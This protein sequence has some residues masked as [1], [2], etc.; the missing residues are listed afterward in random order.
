[1]T[2]RMLV[3]IIRTIL[4]VEEEDEEEAVCFFETANFSWLGSGLRL[5]LVVFRFDRSRNCW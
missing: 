4:S 2:Q 1:M 3:V 5:N